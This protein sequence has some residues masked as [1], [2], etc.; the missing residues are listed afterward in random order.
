MSVE[1]R[2]WEER[3][4]GVLAQSREG[5]LSSYSTPTAIAPAIN[6]TAHSTDIILQLSTQNHL[7]LIQL[8]ILPLLSNFFL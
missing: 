2:D 3:L 1:L 5:E 8:T 7:Y 4:R 6:K